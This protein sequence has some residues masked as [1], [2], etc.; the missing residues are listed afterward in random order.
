LSTMF[1]SSFWANQYAN[2]DNSQAHYQTM[3]EIV[4]RLGGRLDYLFIAI[5]TCGTLRGCSE[6]RKQRGLPTR[7]IAVDAVGSVIS[8]GRKAKRLIPG[9]GA[10]V[11][12]QLY[13]S[14]LADDFVRVND[15]DCVVG[16]HRL[17]EQEALL[18]GGS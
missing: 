17:L 12:P 8:S 10:A 5:S 18:A 4:T 3:D 13:Y 14:G 9:Y 11:L 6:Y 16:C 7:I 15:Q 1:T 2:E